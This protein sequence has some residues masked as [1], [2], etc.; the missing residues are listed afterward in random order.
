MKV[1]T[2]PKNFENAQ[3]TSYG[4]L[5][6]WFCD[7]L[8]TAHKNAT[9]LIQI[10]IALAALFQPDLALGYLNFTNFLSDDWLYGV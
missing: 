7:R 3:T 6:I 9:T 1:V 10:S 5:N 4:R 8:R 2:I